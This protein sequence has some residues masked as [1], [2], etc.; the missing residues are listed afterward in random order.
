[1]KPTVQSIENTLTTLRDQYYKKRDTEVNTDV[2]LYR[3]AYK[4]DFPEGMGFHEVKSPN[5]RNIPD[6]FADRIGKGR[7]VAHMDPRKAGP[8]EKKHV[9]ILER[10]AVAIPDLAR[11]RMKQNP[12]R[13]MA[14]H[15]ANRGA[16]V[17]KFQCNLDDFT[18]APKQKSGESA[19]MFAKR[20]NLWKFE[21]LSRFPL[22]MD[23]R[24]IESIYP[25]P[26]SDG[27]EYVIEAYER[28]AGDIRKNLPHWAGWVTEPTSDGGRRMTGKRYEDNDRVKYIEV[29]TRTWRAVVIDGEFVPTTEG[30]PAAPVPNPYGRP[31]YWVRFP[32]GDPA[33][34]PEGRCVGLLRAIRY[35][36]KSESRMLSIIDTL[37]ENEAYGATVIS[38]K[39]QS[40]EDTMAFGPGSIIKTDTPDHPPKAYS[41][42]NNIDKVMAAFGLVQKETE[43]GS[44]PSAAIGQMQNAPGGGS[45]PPS[46]VAASIL[47]G[48]SS[49]V[50]DPVKTAIE[51][52]Y[53]EF[54]PF[55]FYFLDTVV[56]K[57]LTVYGM[58][59]DNVYFNVDLNSDTIDG[60]Y[61][62]VYVTLQLRD[63][64][65]D[66]AKMNVGAQLLDK[67][68]LEFVLEKFFSIENSA[69]TVKRM[70]VQRLV[71][72]E[73]M[74]KGYLLP[75]LIEQL[76]AADKNVAPSDPG[77]KIAAPMG[78]PGAVQPVLGPN[79]VPMDPAAMAAAGAAAPQQGPNDMTGASVA[80]MDM[81]TRA[82]M[83]VAPGPMVPRG[84]NVVTP[85]GGA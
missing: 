66:F 62:P 22:L 63:P 60:H 61:G 39:D 58:V 10:A 5:T 11:K 1:M 70:M 29:W 69:E 80:G 19:S 8:E 84:P 25:D 85:G 38:S 21:Q 51:D 46:G 2:E 18:D 27:D 64:E 59:G 52:F 28:T 54:I 32:F 71:Q 6:R 57:N 30:A 55:C 33:D 35:T 76:Q 72:S 79:G 44:V 13:G 83:H 34:P 36:A 16:F 77:R 73:E 81:A 37:A 50:V 42:Q 74:L 48:E 15:S 7:I 41:P 3:Q 56:K 26:G 4:L 43:R 47:T 9:E 20:T 17:V 78:A 14:L 65:D 67:L 23:V 82:S 75:R 68:P 49:M 12:N 53:A 31:P 45:A 40:A 24:P